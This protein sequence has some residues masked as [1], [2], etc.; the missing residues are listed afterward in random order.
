MT[1]TKTI[2]LG[3]ALFSKTQ[4]KV[5]GLLF[6][7]PDQSYFTN[8]IVRWA[9]LGKGTVMRELEKL[10]AAGL[11]TRTQK[12]NQNHYQANIECP[13]Y[14]DIAAI[15]RKT[16]GV[17]DLLT[18]VLQPL[19]A[20]IML[21]FIYGSIAKEAAT[22][23]SDIDLMLVGEG[24]DYGSVIELFAPA[25][26]SLSRSINPTIYTPQD[27]SAKLADGNHFLQRVLSQPI[28][29]LWG[30]EYLETLQQGGKLT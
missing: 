22:A 25:E 3:D 4:Q 11:I 24:I 8:E 15:V 23:A 27:I 10:N 16:F 21:A 2:T 12:G 30:G 5:L 9:G 13:I 7:K 18:Q 1:A 26:L 28:I 17:A 20:N 6:S 14:P 29:T 19:R